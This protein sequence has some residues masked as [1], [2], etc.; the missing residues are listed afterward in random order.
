MFLIQSEQNPWKRPGAKTIF[1]EQNNL[2][3]STGCLNKYNKTL[4]Y[5]STITL[6]KRNCVT[7]RLCLYLPPLTSWNVTFKEITPAPRY[8]DIINGRPLMLWN[9]MLARCNCTIFYFTPRDIKFRTILVRKTFSWQVWLHHSPSARA[10]NSH[11]SENVSSHSYRNELLMS[12][13]YYSHTIGYSTIVLLRS[14]VGRFCD[15]IWPT[16]SELLSFIW[17]FVKLTLSDERHVGSLT[18]R[19]KKI[20]VKCHSN[21]HLQDCQFE[22]MTFRI[23]RMSDVSISGFH[24]FEVSTFGWIDVKPMRLNNNL[25]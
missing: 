3:K 13:L 10:A 16:S 2:T 20:R 17:H 8:G 12:R 25:K 23:L 22:G 18:S 9:R 14:S 19:V 15:G 1:S 21:S 5:W 11:S 6:S 24:Y 7:P 4:L